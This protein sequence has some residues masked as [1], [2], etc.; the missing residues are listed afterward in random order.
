MSNWTH[1]TIDDLKTSALGFVVD[2]ARTESVG[3][4]DPAEEAIAA[5]VARVRRAITGSP[6]DADTAK[7][8][9]SL[10]AVAV[11]LALFAL[12]ERLGSSLS[13]DQQMS[14]EADN[15]DLLRISDKRIPVERPDTNAGTAE[16]SPMGGIV[17]VNVPPRLTGR[18]RT[19]GL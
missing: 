15:S 19:S 10:K 2:K 7:V 14:R 8:P 9:K 6:L 18:E 1:I 12:M 4:S 5:A 16:M 13:K 11:R 3:A 17:A